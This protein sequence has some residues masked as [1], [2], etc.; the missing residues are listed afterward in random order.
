LVSGFGFG[1]RQ[2]LGHLVPRKEENLREMEQSG[3]RSAPGDF[4]GILHPESKETLGKR[5][6]PAREARRENFGVFDAWTESDGDWTDEERDWTDQEGDWTDQEGDW[7]ET[8][9]GTDSVPE[10]GL[11]VSEIWRD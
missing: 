6:N 7:T 1:F 11:M 9:S 3:A 5:S 4:W 8:V 2:I 10:T